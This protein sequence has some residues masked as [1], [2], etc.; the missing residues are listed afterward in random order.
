MRSIPPLETG[1]WPLTFEGLG[2]QRSDRA[3]RIT[4]PSTKHARLI[5][6]VRGS[7]SRVKAGLRFWIALGVLITHVSFR[8][9]FFMSQSR[10]ISP[11]AYPTRG[12]SRRVWSVGPHDRSSKGGLGCLRVQKRSGADQDKSLDP[13]GCS[14]GDRLKEPTMG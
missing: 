3:A 9:M 7:T 5:P 11:T 13:S 10:Q 4:T 6:P 8:I 1:W 2:R 14:H 12:V